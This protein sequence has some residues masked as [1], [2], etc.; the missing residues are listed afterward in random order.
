M[1]VIGCFS[2]QQ[3]GKTTIAKYVAQKLDWKRASFAAEVKRIFCETFNVDEEF[4][5]KWKT[6]PEP[7]PGFLMPVRQALQFIGSGFRQ[8]D[9]LVWV[10][11][12]FGKPINEVIVDDGRYL[13]TET[14]RQV[15]GINVLVYRP[16]HDNDDPND[17]ESQIKPVLEFFKN[18]QEGP[19]VLDCL[20]VSD[21][22]GLPEGAEQI[23]FYLVNDGTKEELYQKL[24]NLLIPYIKEKFCKKC[25]CHSGECDNIEGVKL[26]LDD[27]VY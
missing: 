3:M 8:I 13:L 15:G 19:V 22:K 4:I 26:E 1:K 2:Q 9:Q 5:E 25:C 10:K 23:D 11:K 21:Q 17:S 12:L 24:D 16:G 7:P 18:Y 6:I 27:A 20:T 14:A